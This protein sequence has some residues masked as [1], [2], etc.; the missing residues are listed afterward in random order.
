MNLNA[1]ETLKPVFHFLDEAKGASG[2]SGMVKLLGVEKNQTRL[3]VHS[4][5]VNA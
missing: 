2:R 3:H 1:G 5:F 4:L